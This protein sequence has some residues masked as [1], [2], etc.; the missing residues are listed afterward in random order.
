MAT[1]NSSYQYI[2]RSNGVK[3][4][5]A[6]YYY[7]ILLYAKTAGSTATGK[8]TVSVKMTLACE[9]DSTFHGWYTTANAKVGGT[10]AFSWSWEMIPNTN[11]SGSSS[12]TAGGVTYKRHIDL[13]EGSVEIDTKYLSKNVTITAS[14]QRLSIDGTPPN[15]LPKT[16]VANVSAEVTLPLI[17]SAS[18]ITSA[19]NVTLG[20]K[21][22]VK[23]TPKSASFRYKLKFAIGNWS[24]T[25]GAIHPNQ[26]SEYTYSGYSIP[27]DVANQITDKPTGTMSVTLYS[28]SD[29]GATTQIGS[30]DTKTFT[31]TVPDN[32]T[33]KPKVSMS[34]SP[35]SSLPAAFAGLYIQGMTKVKATLSATGQYGA[36]IASYSMKVDEV[37]YG[38]AASYT[39]GYLTT[40][41]S[42]TVYGYATDKRT[43]TGETSQQI[44][45]IAYGNPTLEGVSVIRCDENGNASDIGTYLKITAKRSYS[46]VVSDGVQK[47]F[48]EIKFRYADNDEFNDDWHTILSRDSLESNEVITDPLLDGAISAQASYTVQVRAIDDVGRYAD[49]FVTVPTAMVYWHR[50]GARNAL[51]L[52]K[53]NERDNAIDSN[54]DFYMNDHKITGLA[55]P[56]EDAD[57]VT[58]GYLKQYIDSRLAALTNS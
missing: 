41:G 43:H 13:K 54:W 2:G 31:V 50:D 35:V 37:L 22:S 57:A 52:G 46:P 55:D 5:G 26:T 23:W 17:P 45:V 56:V 25:T 34:I 21:C 24:Y 28:Y 12:I 27:L 1:L 39:S 10:N 9:A 11:W 7:Y 19:S 18:T 40:V 30:A 51:G 15:Y 48:C 29:S 14:W 36:D 42:R 6:S 3:A 32:S 38:A 44:N 33:T 16:T 4:Y 20:N 49:A 53:Y 58:L 8:H 47:N